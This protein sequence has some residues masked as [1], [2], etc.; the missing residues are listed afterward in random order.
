METKYPEIVVKLVGTNGNAVAIMGKVQEALRKAR[1][2]S[3]P[4]IKEATEGD[5]NQLLQTTMRWVTIE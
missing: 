3:A 4:Y 1:I 2:D 5:Y